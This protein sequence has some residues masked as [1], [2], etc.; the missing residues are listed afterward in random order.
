VALDHSAF[1]VSFPTP[2]FEGLYKILLLQFRDVL[3]DSLQWCDGGGG[4]MV[5]AYV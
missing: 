4:G 5:V 3:V 1:P 2:L